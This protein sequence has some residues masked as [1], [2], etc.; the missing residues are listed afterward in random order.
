M[1]ANNIALYDH[2]AGVIIIGV[3]ALVCIGF[4]VMTVML[5]RSGK[6]KK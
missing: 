1:V 5:F 3:F 6:K 2:S 4:I